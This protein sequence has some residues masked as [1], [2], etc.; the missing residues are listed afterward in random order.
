[1][2]G[3]FLTGTDR[4]WLREV[5]PHFAQRLELEKPAEYLGFLPGLWFAA[6]VVGRR[7]ILVVLHH[8]IFPVALSFLSHAVPRSPPPAVADAGVT[9]C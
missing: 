1:M 2:R 8:A 5:H 4:S 3:D 7:C 9:Q 6:P